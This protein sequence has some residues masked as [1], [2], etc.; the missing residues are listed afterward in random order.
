MERHELEWVV[1]QD[2]WGIST[3][4]IIHKPGEL[5]SLSACLHVDTEAVPLNSIVA[6]SHS[7]QYGE[8]ESREGPVHDFN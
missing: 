5:S 8:Q 3:H 7:I 2:Q 1:P 4:Q 6:V